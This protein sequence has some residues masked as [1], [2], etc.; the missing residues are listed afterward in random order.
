MGDFL[1]QQL[2][3]TYIIIGLTTLHTHVDW[4]GVGLCGA[5]DLRGRNAIENVFAATGEE[6]LLLD[7]KPRSPQTFLD[8]YIRYSTFQSRPLALTTSFDALVYIKNSLAM[9]PLR[10]APCQ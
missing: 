10:W 2:G 5:L 3:A 8:P 6:Y 9:H 1:K 7:L 4:L